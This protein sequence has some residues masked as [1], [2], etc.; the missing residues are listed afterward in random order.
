MGKSGRENDSDPLMTTESI[1]HGCDKHFSTGKIHLC[2]HEEYLKI[3][4]FPLK[5]RKYVQA[6][7]VCGDKVK[8]GV[9][10]KNMANHKMCGEN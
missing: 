10:S 7:S 2:L 5:R 6:R 8:E 1:P 4:G 3:L 9:I